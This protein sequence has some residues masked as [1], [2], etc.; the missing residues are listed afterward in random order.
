VAPISEEDGVADVIVLGVKAK[1][2]RF[3]AG[4]ELDITNN[5]KRAKDIADE[6]F[7]LDPSTSNEAKIRAFIARHELGAKAAISLLEQQSDIDSRNLLAAFYLELNDKVNCQRI[8]DDI[9]QHFEPNAESHRIKALLHLVQK[10]MDQ[11]LV[12]IE[13]ARELVPNWVIILYT[14]A[15]IDYYGALSVSRSL[16]NGCFFQNLWIWF[17][18]ARRREI[19][20]KTRET[21]G[22]TKREENEAEA[23]LLDMAV[24][25]QND[26]PTDI[27]KLSTDQIF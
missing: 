9:F 17:G 6:A 22:V 25:L 19:E 8:L 27:M 18:E 4:L 23:E 21:D 24:S 7:N 5:V 26:Q 10:N 20:N 15:V 3:E 2:L 13:K 1:I 11:A 16:M 14:S 12:E